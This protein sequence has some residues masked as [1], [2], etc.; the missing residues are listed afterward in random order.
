M[1]FIYGVVTY[2]DM[3]KDSYK[4]LMYTI[5]ETHRNSK[6]H[7]FYPIPLWVI[8][9]VTSNCNWNQALFA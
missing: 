5:N 1:V 9:V 3:E 4:Y 7:V 8:R 2:V 6:K